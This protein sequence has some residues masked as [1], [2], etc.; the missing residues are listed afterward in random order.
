MRKVD[1]V[2]TLQKLD[3][4]AEGVQEGPPKT[5]EDEAE[6]PGEAAAAKRSARLESDLS[7]LTS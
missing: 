4:M 5:A 7:C 3:W 6:D 1:R 2:T